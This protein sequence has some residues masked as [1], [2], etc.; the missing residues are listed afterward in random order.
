M[1]RER[2]LTRALALAIATCLLPGGCEEQP[3]IEPS[4]GP[5]I[6]DPTTAPTRPGTEGTAYLSTEMTQM[7]HA[8][9]RP[10]EERNIWDAVNDYDLQWRETAFFVGMQRVRK[11]QPLSAEGLKL[12][13]CPSYTSLI[14]DPGRY[15][16]RPIRLSVYVYRLI[17]LEP[18]KDFAGSRRWPVSDGPVWRLDCGNALAKHP[19]DE[20]LLVFCAFD[21]SSL[22]GKPYQVNKDGQA[23]Y[24][25]KEAEIAG[26]F[27]KIY[28]DMSRGDKSKGI[29]PELRSYPVALAWQV[30]TALSRATPPSVDSRLIAIIFIVAAMAV[31]YLILR[32]TTKPP[33][34]H[35]VRRRTYRPL[36]TPEMEEELAKQQKRRNQ[37]DQEADIDPLLKAAS[38]QYRK[39]K[40]LDHG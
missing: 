33:A 16:A 12:L 18:G 22:L 30:N 37:G 21:P 27:Y 34:V 17:K 32:R 19:A 26:I 35:R 10:E 25:H 31:A 7:Y 14:A 5:G 40:G 39:E 8:L 20:P 3:S 6:A 15:R 24:K 36:R 9:A 4:R 2:I 29:E 28:R 13:D 1:K 23:I 38:E 11:V